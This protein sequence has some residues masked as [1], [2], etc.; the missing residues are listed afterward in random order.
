MP[1]TRA[2]LV[3][4]DEPVTEDGVTQQCHAV[5]KEPEGHYADCAL[6]LVSAL[7]VQ[8]MGYMGWIPLSEQTP[9]PMSGYIALLHP[10]K[11]EPTLAFVGTRPG[12]FR[13]DGYTDYMPIARVPL[14]H[15]QR[16]RKAKRAGTN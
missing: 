7:D 16:R 3:E 6:A 15:L 10:D 14:E 12:D 13:E 2:W 9:H 1:D 5:L 11:D 4:F 8:N